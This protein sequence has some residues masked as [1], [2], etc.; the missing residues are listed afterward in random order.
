[1]LMDNEKQIDNS[2]ICVW[3]CVWV[4]RF[5]D[6]KSKI[7]RLSKQNSLE[8]TNFPKSTIITFKIFTQLY[9]PILDNVR[10]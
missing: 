1:M 3:R 6:N 8:F 4:V 5:K 9:L 7:P 2:L 10:T